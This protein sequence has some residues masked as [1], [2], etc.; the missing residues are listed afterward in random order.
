M[1]FSKFVRFF[2]RWRK[3][4]KKRGD[5][6]SGRLPLRLEVLIVGPGGCGS[7]TLL[8]HVSK[9]FNCNDPADK[10]G[11]KHLPAPP[12]PEL[13]EKIIYVGGEVND[14]KESL[15]RRGWILRQVLKLRPYP[16]MWKLGGSFNF[17]FLVQ[18]QRGKFSELRGTPVLFVHYN[19][20]FESAQIISDFLGHKDGFVSSFPKRQERKSIK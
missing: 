17:E 3:I 11:L 7:T 20:L 14:M 18:L 9:Y 8:R 12:P 19:D 5:I 6:L 16:S 4:R 10:D 15:R 1:R 13:A 2:F